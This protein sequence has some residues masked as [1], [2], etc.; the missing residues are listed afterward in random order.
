[1]VRQQKFED[2]EEIL[3]IVICV[4]LYVSP[5]P[6]SS[7]CELKDLKKQ[8][9]PKDRVISDLEGELREN[10]QQNQKVISLFK[11]IPKDDLY[12]ITC[13]E[14]YVLPGLSKDH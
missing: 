10:C 6:C 12:K 9:Q 11:F 4:Y 2:I 3:D 5:P 7:A 14:C 8:L 1:M 13:Q